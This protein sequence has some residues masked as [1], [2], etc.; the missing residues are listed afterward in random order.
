MN[1]AGE[2]VLRR[3]VASTHTPLLEGRN[4]K[5]ALAQSRVTELQHTP[6]FLR[7]ETET[8]LEERSEDNG[9]NTHPSF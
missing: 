7:G 2:P 1:E 9:F 8:P 4:R 5:W 3:F 6:L